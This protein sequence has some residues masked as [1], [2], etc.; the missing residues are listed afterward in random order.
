MELDIQWLKPPMTRRKVYE[1]KWLFKPEWYK[2][3][4]DQAIHK[5]ENDNETLDI[6]SKSVTAFSTDNEIKSVSFENLKQQLA[7][8]I[9][10]ID[11]IK[12]ANAYDI[13]EFST[14]KD[15]VGDEVLD[16]ANIQSQMKKH[17]ITRSFIWKKQ[18]SM[19]WKRDF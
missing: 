16:G 14:L 8:Y 10:V 2:S 11:A 15:L 9:T 5:L 6:V 4:C 12:S 3:Q 18:M 7:D 19:K 17:L 13:A 1:R